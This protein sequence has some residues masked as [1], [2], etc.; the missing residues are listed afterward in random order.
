[1]QENTLN[2]REILLL[3]ML[4]LVEMT[5]WTLDYIKTF[6]YEEFSEIQDTFNGVILARSH[7]RK[8]PKAYGH[9]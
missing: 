8:N 4:H 5:G 3:E 1:M 7:I 2:L 9:G 6:T